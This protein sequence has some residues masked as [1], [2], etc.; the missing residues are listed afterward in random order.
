VID[1]RDIWRAAGLMVKRYKADAPV[2]AA[3]RAD[4]LLAEGDLDG[5]AVGKRILEAISGLARMKPAEGDRV[6]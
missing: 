4:E 3:Q 5:V 2:M 1:D 6:N